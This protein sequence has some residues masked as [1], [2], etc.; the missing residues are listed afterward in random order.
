MWF[1][2]F[3]G[4]LKI[5]K[6]KLVVCLILLVIGIYNYKFVKWFD[7]KLKFLFVNNYIVSVILFVND[8][9]KMKIGN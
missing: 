6:N 1:V 2:Y 9:Y 4:L 3:Y 7:N 8:F 5:Y